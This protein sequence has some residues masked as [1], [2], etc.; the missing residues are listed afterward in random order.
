[1]RHLRFR[2][3]ARTSVLGTAALVAALSLTACQG[4][5]PAPAAYDA[6]APVSQQ[7]ADGTSAAP[8]SATGKDGKTAGNTAT[9]GSGS[10]TAK[11]SGSAAPKPA[12]AAKQQDGKGSSAS[13]PACTGTNTELTVTSVPRPVNHMLLTVTN[14]GS[15]ACHAYSY[16]FLRFGEAQSVPRSVEASKPQA[17]VTIAPGESAYA[18]IM[19]SSPDGSGTGGY[20]TEDLAVGFQDANAGSAGRMVSVPLGKEVYVDSTLAVT[21]WQNGM[22]DALMY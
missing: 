8:V 10:G 5:S 2:H 7:P 12:A 19:T 1:M 9:A 21:Y 6:G 22:E 17:V 16:P 3:A 15:K 20:S 18:G 11:D 13:L 4:S 14:T